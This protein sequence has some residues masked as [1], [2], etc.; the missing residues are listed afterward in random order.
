MLDAGC[1]SGHFSEKLVSLVGKTGHITSI[2][3]AFE[4]VNMVKNHFQELI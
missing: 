4:S 2:D 1:G 3:S